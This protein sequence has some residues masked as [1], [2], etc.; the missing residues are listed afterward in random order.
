MSRPEILVSWRRDTL[1]C[2]KV[3]ISSRVALTRIVLAQGGGE[4]R[5]RR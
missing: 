4:A 3:G 2:V 1:D 5:L